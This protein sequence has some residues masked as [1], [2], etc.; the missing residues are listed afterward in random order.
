[1]GVLWTVWPLDEQM[2]NWLEEQSIA[3]PN[4]PSRFPTGAEIKKALGSLNGYNIAITDN[5]LGASWQASIVHTSGG[6]KGPWTQLNISHYSGEELPQELWFE[7]GWESLI[8]EILQQLTL[9]CGPLTL[10]ADTGVEP[11]VIAT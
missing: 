1:M 7:K 8:K 5:G 2:R 10:M 4:V 6:D 11:V 9:A 3:Y